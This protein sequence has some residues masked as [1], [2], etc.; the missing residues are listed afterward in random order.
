M[1]QI[2]VEGLAEL[3]RRLR[4]LPDAIAGKG[5]GPLR[6]AIFQAAKVIKDQA[7]ANAPEDTGLL[8]KNIVTARQ[9][10]NPRGR[11]GYFIEVRRKRRHYANTRANVR[12]GKVGK[13]YDVRDAYY[14][15]M[16]EFGTQNMPAQ[17]FMR[18]AFESKKEQAAMQFRESFAKAI[19]MAVR[20]LTRGKT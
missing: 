3:S 2:R 13:T 15:M 20:K 1:A 14:G 12:K 4:E 8:K 9:R 17:P 19:E 18:P 10:K 11:E 7:I 5:G 16:I 6:Y